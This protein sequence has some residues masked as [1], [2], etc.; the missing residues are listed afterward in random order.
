M[1][2]RRFKFQG[3]LVTKYMYTYFCT[4]LCFNGV[5]LRL[6]FWPSIVLVCYSAH[7]YIFNEGNL[8]KGENILGGGEKNIMGREQVIVVPVYIRVDKTSLLAHFLS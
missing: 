8:V 4:I 3:I 2:F 5:D 7:S 6:K 1:L